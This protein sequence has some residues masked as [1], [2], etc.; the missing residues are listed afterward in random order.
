MDVDG[1]R[2]FGPD[3]TS[4]RNG[5][6]RKLIIMELGDAVKKR[7][8]TI[9]FKYANTY[10]QYTIFVISLLT[11]EVWHLDGILIFILSRGQ[12]M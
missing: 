3:K 4:Q 9:G 10:G 1:V 5:V 8:V 12:W 6:R 2:R 11:V 7:R